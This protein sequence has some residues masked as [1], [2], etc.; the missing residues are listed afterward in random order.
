MGHTTLRSVLTT[1]VY[2]TDTP[3]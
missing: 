2:W 1:L 3:P